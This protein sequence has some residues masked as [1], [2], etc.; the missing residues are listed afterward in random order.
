MYLS[1]GPQF[2]IVANE[3]LS[4][5]K[6][7]SVCNDTTIDEMDDGDFPDTELLDQTCKQVEDCTKMNT[8]KEEIQE[9]RPPK[10]KRQRIVSFKKFLENTHG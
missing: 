6:K 8:V 9:S 5:Q 7:R 1:N 4:L 2:L 10:K 3:N